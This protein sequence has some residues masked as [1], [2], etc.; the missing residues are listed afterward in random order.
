[1]ESGDETV[2]GSVARVL[3]SESG[4]A[5]GPDAEKVDV[6]IERVSVGSKVAVGDENDG[7]V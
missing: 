7:V 4:T 3:E 1:M 6:G 2:L 5:T